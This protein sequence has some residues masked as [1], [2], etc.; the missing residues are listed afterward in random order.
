MTTVNQTND[1]IKN[2]IMSLY[3]PDAPEAGNKYRLSADLTNK[4]KI[5]K[6]KKETI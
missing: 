5:S 1:Q 3:A 2:T 4:E 6:R